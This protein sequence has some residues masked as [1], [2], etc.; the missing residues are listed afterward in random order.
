MTFINE[1]II[2]ENG[3]TGSTLSSSTLNAEV[4]YADNLHGDGS[5]LTFSGINN[6][7]L[8]KSNNSLNASPNFQYSADTLTVSGDSYFDGQFFLTGSTSAKLRYQWF[9]RQV[10][11]SSPTVTTVIINWNNMPFGTAHTWLN[12]T[13]NALTGDATFISDLTEY[14]EVRFF[15]SVFSSSANSGKSLIVQIS[16][17]NSSW[18]N[19]SSLLMGTNGSPLQSKDS[20][21]ISIPT[22]FRNFVYLRLVGAGGTLVS[23][24]RFSPP[25]LLIR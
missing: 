20:G 21:W 1:N 11:G 10:Q 25:T 4:V 6:S 5:N 18:T 2:S 13:A 7:V 3:L 16:L 12:T 9:G 19:L 23:S 15:F 22:N 17:D 8:F 14:T 24:P